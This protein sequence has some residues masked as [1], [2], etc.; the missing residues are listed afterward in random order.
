[1]L[2]LLHEH[3][4]HAGETSQIEEHAN[5]REFPTKTPRTIIFHNKFRDNA[6]HQ[7]IVACIIT[8]CQPT[9]SDA[10][11]HVDFAIR[12]PRDMPSARAV[13]SAWVKRASFSAGS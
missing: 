7:Q 12:S 13:Q 1:M 3:I 10:A 8:A 2:T 4:G 9:K 11:I 5:C 6:M